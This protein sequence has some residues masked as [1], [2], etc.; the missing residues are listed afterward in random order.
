LYYTC[1]KADAGSQ[2]ELC[3]GDSKVQARVQ[4]AWDPPEIGR[5][6]DRV[7]RGQESWWKDF[8]PLKLG[9]IRL[10]K[11]RGILMLR[12]MTVAGRQVADVRRIALTRIA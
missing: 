3:F 12:A 1:A 9:T 4:P 6:Y 8:R 7:D 2:I 5:E 10:T 11:G